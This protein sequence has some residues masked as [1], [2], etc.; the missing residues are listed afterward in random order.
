MGGGRI[1]WLNNSF[2]LN[3]RDARMSKLNYWTTVISQCIAWSSA[4]ALTGKCW[5]QETRV[6]LLLTGAS[7]VDVVQGR[8]I[9]HQSIRI[10]DG[11]IQRI[12]ADEKGVAPGDAQV[13]DVSGLVILPGLI[14]L[15][16]H[17]L[18]HPY[19][20]AS[21]NDQVLKE[22]LELRV[23]RATVHAQRTLEAGFTT[24]RDLGTEGAAFADV[25]L[26]DAIA[27]KMILGPSVV[28]STKAIVTTGGYG[29]TGFD[30][31]FVVPKGA[32]EADGPDA[33]RRAVREQIAAGA[34]WI[35]LYVDYRRKSG[36]RSTPTFSD[37]EIQA[38]VDEA[39]SAGVPVSAHATTD[40][41]IR[42]A[43]IGGVSTVEHGYEASLQTLRLMKEHGVVL[44]PTLAASE[45]MAVY[46]GW[47]PGQPDHP[48]IATAKLLMKNA[49]DIGVPIACGSDAGVFAHGDNARELELMFAYGMSAA[50]V[51]RSATQSA[52]TVL[53]RSNDLGLIAPNYQADLVAIHDN[54][55]EDLTTLRK[56]VL[57]IKSGEIV[58]DR[59]DARG[60]V[61]DPD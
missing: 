23:I 8:L 57:V 59:R 49:I 37:A 30:P 11:R 6:E 27:Q 36:D 12:S 39:K 20:E 25:A 32:Q 61:S 52:A 43:V 47:T 13:I 34:D 56:P 55:L 5:A 22:A 58:V 44:C 28:T 40:E 31:R 48:R 2:V 46:D 42:R 29:P 1:K 7:V 10:L 9:E 50:D 21:W 16:T 45:A 53:G 19:N 60:P 4:L 14:D 18:L 54:P 26:R 35:K 17:L 38:A 24:I 15:H 51:L 33:V 3:K 41:G